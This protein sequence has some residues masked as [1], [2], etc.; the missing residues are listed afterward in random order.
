MVLTAEGKC[1]PEAPALNDHGGPWGVAVLVANQI[2][3]IFKSITQV[4]FILL[5]ISDAV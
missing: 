4:K 1:C 5:E 2:S 3:V